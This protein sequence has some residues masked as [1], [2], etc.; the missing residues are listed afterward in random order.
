MEALLDCKQ[1]IGSLAPLA[2]LNVSI[3]LDP[4]SVDPA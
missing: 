2:D 4:S 3:S 1:A